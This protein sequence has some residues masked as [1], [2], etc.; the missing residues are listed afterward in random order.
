[1]SSTVTDLLTTL[2]TSVISVKRSVKSLDSDNGLRSGL[3]KRQSVALITVLFIIILSQIMTL[4]EWKCK[5]F[6]VFHL[7]FKSWHFRCF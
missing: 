7:F 5:S 3:S 6:E 4:R 1:M 2:A